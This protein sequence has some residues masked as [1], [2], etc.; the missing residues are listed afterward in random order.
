MKNNFFS[1]VTFLLIIF[2]ALFTGPTSDTS[3]SG[4]L[5]PI[6]DCGS[7]Y[8]VR[9]GDTLSAIAVRCGIS[10]TNLMSANGLR[11]TSVIYPGQRLVI[12]G[13]NT[14]AIQNTASAITTYAGCSNP[15]VVR[16]GDTLN[17]IAARCGVTVYTL[18]QRNGLYS[19]LIRVGQLLYVQNAA[20]VAPTIA[21]TPHYAG[22]S[23]VT[24]TA[25]PQPYLPL[26]IVEYLLPY[27][28]PTPQ[29]E[30]PISLW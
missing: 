25:T 14:A 18:K 30:S 23:G 13:A 1:F 15:Y 12:P 22:Y 29:I 7:V 21:P 8:T 4:R 20:S 26:T 6:T 10:L 17:A 5:G 9:A 24:A 28:T 11:I 2:L 27:P 16:A 19:D 3:A